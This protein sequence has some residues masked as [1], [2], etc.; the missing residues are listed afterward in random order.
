MSDI[1]GFEEA[2]AHVR[3]LPVYLLLD[4]SASMSGA[5][6]EAVNQGMM[7]LHN[8]LRSN[9]TAIETAFI[10][11]ITFGSSAN[12]VVPLTE[13]ASFQPPRIEARGSTSLGSALAL[14]NQ[15]LDNDIISNKEGQKGDYKPLVFLMT[16]GMPTD[17]YKKAAEQL[18]SRQHAKPVIIALGCGSGADTSALKDV[19]QVVLKMDNMTS[20]QIQE[21][22]QWLSQ[23]VGTASV[24]A[25]QSVNQDVEVKLEKPPEGIQIVI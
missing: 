13:V 21:Y 22:F 12:M 23:S 9:P 5:P 7:L 19:A 10:A 25:Q 24:S 20:D 11:V 2:Q 14:L 16:D 6:I 1:F 3:R 15:S 8:E 4:V 18:K 17:D